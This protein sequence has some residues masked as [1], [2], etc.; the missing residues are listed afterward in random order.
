MHG[1]SRVE[2]RGLRLAGALALLTALLAA[3]LCAGAAAKGSA[4]VAGAAHQAASPKPRITWDTA[5]DVSPPLRVLAANR[6]APDAEDP[7]DEPDL[8]PTPGADSGYSGDGALQ[9]ALGPAAIP[10]T[11][12]NFERLSNHDI[13][14]R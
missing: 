3:A 13:A 10:S 12:H 5:H 4:A 1:P 8:G 6:V 7:A 14:L 11:Q 9:S 2:P